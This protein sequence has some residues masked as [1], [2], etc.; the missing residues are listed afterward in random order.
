MQRVGHQHAVE[1]MKVKRSRE[2]RDSYVESAFQ[3]AY[4]TSVFVDRGDV[5]IRPNKLRERES[6]GTGPCTKVGPA[7]PRIGD[8][9]S[10]QIY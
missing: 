9:I 2:V 8:S 5:R 10:N 6:E 3:T 4:R 7:T 1:V